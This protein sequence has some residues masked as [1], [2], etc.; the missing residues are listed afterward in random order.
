M[1]TDDLIVPHRPEPLSS[2]LLPV[3]DLQ[4]FARVIPLVGALVRAMRGDA[5]SVDLL[6]VVTGNFLA[7]LMRRIDLASGETP[8]PAEM[9]ALH[10]QHLDYT[11]LPLLDRSRD[12]LLRETG[13]GSPE[14]LVRDGDPAKVINEIS[15]RHNY[16]ALIMNRRTAVRD[17]AKLIGSVVAGVMHRHTESTIYLVGD[18]AEPAAESLFARCLIAV[19]ASPASMNGANEAASILSRVNE[20]V[21]QVYLVHVLDQSCYYD[22]DGESCMDLSLTGQQALEQAGNL[23]L[24]RGVDGD[25]IKTV[26]HFGKPGT[27]LAEEVQSCDATLIFLGRRDR[28]RMAQVFLGSVCTDIIQNC[29]ER[30]LVLT[31]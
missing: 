8:S 22:E 28:S 31:S 9:R 11:V 3:N 10:Q 19:D 2:I 17:S 30:T 25:K 14:T 26:I 5:R 12:L 29:R 27:V 21:E 6:H 15:S 16:S 20:Q 4:S 24:E 1:T 7:E 13:I 18:A 23:L